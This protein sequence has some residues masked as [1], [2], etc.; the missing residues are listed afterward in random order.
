MWGRGFESVS[1][2]IAMRVCGYASVSGG[3]AMQCMGLWVE[4]D[5]E[6]CLYNNYIV[7]IRHNI[8]TIIII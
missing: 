7:I 3:V 2:G 8:L 4:L 6:E 5:N 1:G